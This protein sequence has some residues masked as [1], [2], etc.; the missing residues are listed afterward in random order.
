MQT[1][2]VIHGWAEGK[3][4]SRRFVE[5]LAKK[6]LQFTDDAHRADVIVAHSS[7]CYLVP[8]DNRAQLIVLIGLPYW[9]GRNY[10]SS[11]IE[12][13]GKEI[14]HH[15][16]HRG[17]GWWLGKL[18]HNCWYIVSR[19][20]ATYYGLTRHSVANLP[21]AGGTGA[22]VVFVRPNDDTFC[23]PDIGK[24]IGRKPGYE[25]VELPGAHDDCWMEP[26]PYLD[27]LERE[28]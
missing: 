21:D 16:R 2:A 20:Q 23:H 7:G 25:F 10:V 4:Q 1:V 15:R 24:L 18:A 26:E 8:R 17:F 13:L 3:W 11:V 6:G 12:K 22:K 14:A 28:T 9:P 19:P 27:L 5:G